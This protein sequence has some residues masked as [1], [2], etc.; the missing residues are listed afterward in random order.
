MKTKMG[1][2]AMSRKRLSLKQRHMT[3]SFPEELWLEV[4]EIR[5]E[6]YK[7]N[8]SRISRRALRRFLENKEYLD[9]AYIITTA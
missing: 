6:G 9:E 5:K 2:L 1:G 8:V 3:I 4:R 7:V